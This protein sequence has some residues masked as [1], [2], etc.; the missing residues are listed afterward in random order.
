MKKILVFTLAF[1][2]CFS[3]HAADGFSTLE[4]RMTGKEFKETGL[5]KLTDEELSALNDW[6]RKRSVATLDTVATPSAAP[7]ASSG[8]TGDM[9][10][11]ENQRKDDG[12]DAD[13]ESTIVG[14]FDGWRE[15]GTQFKLSNG[16][17]WQQI[18]ADAFRVEP[19][20]DAEIV[21]KRSIMGGW[22]LSVV[23]YGSSVRVKRIK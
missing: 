21:I 15:I 8:Q 22:R 4:E 1:A 10:G 5:V 13:I 20:E 16:M 11:F 23:G 17:V 12:S 18:E 3:A 19:T 14:T 6:I 7:T 9:R 2:V